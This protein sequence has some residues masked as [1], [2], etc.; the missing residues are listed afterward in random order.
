MIFFDVGVAVPVGRA[1]E[2]DIK[3]GPASGVV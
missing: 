2:L 1:H 3:F